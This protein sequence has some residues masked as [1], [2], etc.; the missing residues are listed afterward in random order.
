[1]VCTLKQDS[2]RLLDDAVEQDGLTN[3]NA[4]G[5]NPYI[6]SPISWRSYRRVIASVSEDNGL[7]SREVKGGG[8]QLG[9]RGRE[10][11]LIYMYLVVCSAASR[12]RGVS[13]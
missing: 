10:E 9:G 4:P 11:A 7:G 12:Q 3:P 5:I 1:M 2:D 8:A 6:E 13:L